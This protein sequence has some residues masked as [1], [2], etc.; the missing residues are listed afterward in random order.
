MKRADHNF[1]DILHQPDVASAPANPGQLGD[2]V[3]LIHATGNWME[4]NVK[5]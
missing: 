1:S 3:G 4:T 5:K 2:G